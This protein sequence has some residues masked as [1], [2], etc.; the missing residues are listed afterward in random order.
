M[1]MSEITRK[2]LESS[3]LFGALS[4]QFARFLRT[5]DPEGGDALFL[6]AALVSEQTS[7]GDICFDLG[8]VAGRPLTVGGET[9][10]GFCAPELPA[11]LERLRFSTVVGRPGE[12]RPLVLDH[13]GRLYLYR[14]WDYQSR[15]AEELLS[16]GG[17]KSVVDE[18]LLGEGL[19]RLFGEGEEGIVDW[20]KVAALAAVLGKFSVISGGPG[21]GKTSTVVKILALLLEQA[22]GAPLHIALAAPT[23]KAAARLQESIAAA[24]QTLPVEDGVRQRIPDQV[25]T[26]HRLLGTIRGSSRFRHDRNNP[27]PCDLV[28]VDEASMVDLPLMVKLVEAVPEQAHLILLGDRDQLA[29][30]EAGAVLADICAGGGLPRF[31]SDFVRRAAEIAG[32]ALPASLGAGGLED[33]LVVLQKSYRFAAD[34][35]IGTLC[36][37]VNAGDGPGA[38]AVCDDPAQ[39]DVRFSPLPG[40]SELTAALAAEVVAG[41][42]AMLRAATV[43]EAFAELGRFMILTP[44][45]RGPWGV[46]GLNTTVEGILQRAGLIREGSRWT[47]GQPLMISA[48][49]YRLGLF[50]GDLGLIL[51]DPDAG[52]QLKA[53]FPCGDGVYRKIIPARLP[54]HQTAYAMTVH[55]S[56]GTEFDRV[57]LLLP[58]EEGGHLARELVYTGISRARRSVALLG[59]RELFA[60]AVAR[61]MVRESGLAEALRGQGGEQEKKVD[62]S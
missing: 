11:W 49:D 41:Y 9:L 3:G 56:Q 7:R 53:F 30:V 61:R 4:L 36:R 19:T 22:E 6:A 47:R 33:A 38:L 48:N 23:G 35:G 5:L 31:S 55:K 45:R 52:G 25:S 32:L 51:P 46:E 12:F 43:E 29:S 50:N 8:A 15:L 39:S 10:P 60:A 27:L 34:S 16:R 37:A 54:E 57:L 17:R 40:V 14:Y 18:D 24:R 44:L 2:T 28:V 42:G 59:G 1:L 20:Q 62:R 21:T 58:G 26:I 13:R